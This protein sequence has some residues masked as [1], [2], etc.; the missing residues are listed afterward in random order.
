MHETN[1]FYGVSEKAHPALSF[2]FQTL[3]FEREGI[4]V[5]REVKLCYVYPT[6]VCTWK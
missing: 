6:N 5:K 4:T 2:P 3:C 1:T